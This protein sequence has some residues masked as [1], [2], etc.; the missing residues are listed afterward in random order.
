M[1][2]LLVF[3][4]YPWRYTRCGDCASFEYFAQ[5]G[6]RKYLFKRKVIVEGEVVPLLATVSENFV[7]LLSGLLMFEPTM[8]LSVAQALEH[9]WF[10]NRATTQ[11]SAHELIPPGLQVCWNG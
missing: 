3:G 4:N 6:L 1:L 11:W 5:H 9:A 10:A 8:R 2:F 7:S